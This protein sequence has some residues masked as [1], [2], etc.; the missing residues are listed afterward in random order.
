LQGDNVATFTTREGLPDNTVSQ[1]LEDNAGYLWLGGN[2]GIVRVSKQELE[3]VAAR[4]I[5]VVYPRFF[6]RAEGML[7]EECSGN[8]ACAGLRNGTGLL[9]F[10]TLK[11]IVVVDPKRIAASAPAPAVV[12]EQTLIDG[13]P[14]SEFRGTATITT[15]G[16]HSE[17]LRLPSD[18]H[19]LEFRYTGLSFDA[20]ERLRFRYR[21]EG[22][23]PDWV[24]AG[25][26]RS[27]F[28]GFVPPGTYRFRVIACNGDGVWNQEGDGQALTVLPHFWQTWWF[29]G[30]LPVGTIALG[31]GAARFIEKRKSQRRL[32]RL[33]QERLLEQE[34]TRIA[35]DLHDTMGA[36]LCRI[37]FM[38]EHVRR[39]DEVSIEVREQISSIS[40]DS[41][42][43]LQS[44]DEIVWAVN[45][46]NDTVEHLA[47]YIGQYAR[48]Y[49]RRTGIECELEIPSKLP[50]RPLSA[51]S[52]HHL[53]LAV[54]EALTNV[55]KHSLATR[56]R[57]AM[58][59]RG[60]EFEIAVTDNGVGM[61]ARTQNDG[62][63]DATA[64][65][66]NG[67]ANMQ[68]RLAELSGRCVMESPAGQGT[69]VR[70]VLSLPDT[71]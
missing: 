42:E 71:L 25:N 17:P 16:L 54:D 13:V 39:N 26:R 15:S 11:G 57:I 70:F 6:G 56:V 29:I 2:R 46:Q 45:P 10:S 8:S 33:E 40:D 66:G 4:K 32:K 36:K 34:R 35:Q 68:R 23:D 14:E 5:Q 7:S 12:L 62:A 24:D 50:A 52:R 20:P 59:S 64:G 51:Q 61:A 63:S 37:S 41:R 65:F 69:T 49:F 27:A 19:R 67:L 31:A 48:E 47:S 53:F 3:E 58:T 38:S 22:L 18:R 28:Y 30:G 9:W 60:D 44:L 55:L 1:I 43:V 21:L